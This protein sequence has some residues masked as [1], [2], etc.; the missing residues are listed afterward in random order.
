MKRFTFSLRASSAFASPLISQARTERYLI[1]ACRHISRDCTI[2]Y[3]ILVA[4][5]TVSFHV[6][7]TAEAGRLVFVAPSAERE[8]RGGLQ[9]DTASRHHHGFSKRILRPSLA[10][11]WATNVLYLSCI[12]YSLCYPRHSF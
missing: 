1:T 4:V 3:L 7:G 2:G 9:H 10:T 11:G 12:L 6:D 5:R 8:T